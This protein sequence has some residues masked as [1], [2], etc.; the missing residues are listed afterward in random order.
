M[1]KRVDRVS[2]MAVVPTSTLGYIHLL[3]VGFSLI[4]EQYANKS[5]SSYHP[6]LPPHPPPP[7][8]ITLLCSWWT[9]LP[10]PLILFMLFVSLNGYCIAA[11]V[12]SEC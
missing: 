11:A 6:Q 12:R 1:S 10:D 5:Y 7:E 3:S 9:V 4:S 8:L 2:R